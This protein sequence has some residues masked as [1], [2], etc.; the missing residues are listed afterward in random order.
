MGDNPPFRA[1]VF[2]VTHRPRE[3]LLRQG[4]TSFAYVTDGLAGAVERA[5]GAANGKNV[6][7]A[8]GGAASSDRRSMPA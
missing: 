3:R 2:V 4:G 1:P 5:R 6:A 8:G 7:I